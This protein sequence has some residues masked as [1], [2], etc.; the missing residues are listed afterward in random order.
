MQIE[1]RELVRLQT[2]QDYRQIVHS[3]PLG[4]LFK[5]QVEVQ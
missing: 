1:Q 4:T 5:G 3:V 2:A